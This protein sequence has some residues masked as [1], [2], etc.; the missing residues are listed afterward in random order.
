MPMIRKISGKMGKVEEG[1]VIVEVDGLGYLVNTNAKIKPSQA[2]KPITFY[3]HL[4]VRE[5]A[6]DLYGFC[7]P[8]E[9]EM[10]EL[11]L[12]LNRVG[13]KSALQIM[14]QAD[15]AILKKAVVN[16][17]APYLTKLSGIGK[18]T[19][20]NIVAGLKGK[21]EDTEEAY[22]Q[23]DTN[24]NQ[25]NISDTIDALISLGYPQRDARLTVQ[26]L[27]DETPE[28]FVDSNAALTAALKRL[29]S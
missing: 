7:S 26:K 12:T 20:E 9:L 10:F 23:K 2:D 17:D 18:K 16:E 5:N 28:L 24:T 6:L 11:L 8:E 13:P 29:G 15:L 1:A 19:A 14:S 21:I 27:S 22:T 4:A 3:T 25:Q